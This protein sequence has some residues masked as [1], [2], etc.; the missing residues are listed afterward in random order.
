MTEF[1]LFLWLYNRF[2]I[3]FSLGALRSLAEGAESTNSGIFLRGGVC[4][5]SFNIKT[6]LIV[7]F[8]LQARSKL[9]RLIQDP[10]LQFIIMFF[11]ALE[12]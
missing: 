5:V 12:L 8:E 2:N 10:I 1:K 11:L 6:S 7:S 4:G 9:E 3:R